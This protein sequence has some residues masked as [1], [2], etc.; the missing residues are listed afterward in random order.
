[1]EMG[2][3]ID[4]IE[5]AEDEAFQ[6]RRMLDSL[7]EDLD[8]PG[9]RWTYSDLELLERLIGACKEYHIGETYS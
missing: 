7:D 5:K 6:I 3:L 4:L 2:D 1:M 8:G 9:E